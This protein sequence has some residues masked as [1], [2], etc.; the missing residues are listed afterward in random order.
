MPKPIG[1]VQFYCY[2]CHWS[3]K[4]TV[5]SDE[6]Y[7]PNCPNCGNMEIQM[8][9]LSSNKEDLPWYKKLFKMPEF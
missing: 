8:E 1:D 6:V 5:R 2:R 4:H 7:M 9:L 3:E